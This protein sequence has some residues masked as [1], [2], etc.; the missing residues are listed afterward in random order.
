MPRKNQLLRYLKLDR[1]GKLTYSRQ[2]PP[3]LR[4]FLGGKA[5]LRRTLGVDSSDCSS[6]PVLTAYARVHSEIDELI[7]QAKAR[8]EGNAALFT[9][10]STAITAP[11]GH[12]PLSRREIAGIA[13]QVLLDI[14]NAAADQR[15]MT[16]EYGRCLAA[17]VMKMKTQGMASVLDADFAVVARPVLDQLQ[18]TPSPADMAAI[19]QA[20]MTYIPVMADDMAKLAA[21]DFSEPK[22]ASVVPPLP[23]RAVTWEQLF[24]GWLLSTGGIT[25]NVGYGVS[26]KRQGPYQTAI[27]EFRQ[28]ITEQPPSEITIDQAR[29]WVRWL[30]SISG[31][32]PG[33]QRTKLLCLRNLMKIG[34]ID[35]VI[36]SNPFDQFKI[37]TPAGAI[38]QSGYRAFSND[39][40][41]KIFAVINRQRRTHNR[42]IPWILLTT[43][44]RLAE[45][46]QLRTY[47]LKQTASGLWFIDWKYQPTGAH[48][49]MLKTKS[50]N[51][52][53]CPMP[54]RLL[55]T[56]ILAIDR[57]HNGRLFPDASQH[58]ASHSKHFQKI[59][60]A[61]GIWEKKKTCLHS[62]RN[63]A[64][65][66]WREAE[67]PIDYRN[68]LTGHQAIGA[69][70]KH[71]GKLLNDM[72]EQLNSQLTKVDLSWLP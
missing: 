8:A 64:K 32:A 13:G 47:D 18:I 72:P 29:A 66:M 42:L 63:N 41:I 23:T 52:R 61:L 53:C 48:P 3:E 40:L 51:N 49:M 10:K 21:L 9:G 12:L 36:S 14:R 26:E 15:L 69:G 43:G 65:Q 6:A 56:G 38:D 20:L 50:D 46:M 59:L 4:P 31:Y 55:E 11:D 57:N 58:T 33:T 35:G 1:L 30:Q 34:V 37:S 60:Q 39:E 16:P 27:R 54:P 70:E 5:T 17:L 2:I 22:I 24:E 68:A 45:A 19:G 67:I 62:L 25:E 28:A 71:Y 44:C 7:T